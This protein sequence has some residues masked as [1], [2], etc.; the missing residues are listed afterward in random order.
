MSSSQEGD[1]SPTETV[2]G[3][4]N[5]G[6]LPAWARVPF[7]TGGPDISGYPAWANSTETIELQAQRLGL[8]REE[9]EPD[10]YFAYR[11]RLTLDQP[12]PGVPGRSL[13]A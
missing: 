4:W 6:R 12:F 5:G 7:G 11:I 8:E 3:R 9:G 10:N 13:A 1:E 2:I